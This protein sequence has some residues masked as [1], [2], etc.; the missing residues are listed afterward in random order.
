MK[1]SNQLAIHVNLKYPVAKFYPHQQITIPRSYHYTPMFL[2]ILK[3]HPELC[4]RQFNPVLE[5]PDLGW[6][7]GLTSFGPCGSVCID[8]S[9]RSLLV[10]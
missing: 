6:L 3:L 2:V 7:R 4:K 10:T 1:T 9:S 8:P 5:G